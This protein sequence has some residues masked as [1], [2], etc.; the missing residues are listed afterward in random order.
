MDDNANVTF[1]NVDRVCV[2]GHRR[3]AAVLYI[4]MLRFKIEAFRKLD[5]KKIKKEVA[6]ERRRITKGS[7]HK[8]LL[9]IYEQLFHHSTNI[10]L[11]T[12]LDLLSLTRDSCIYPMIQSATKK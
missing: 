4:K 10:Q 6:K 8:T 1:E 2:T 12:A 3:H 11:Q 7:V 9:N 5:D